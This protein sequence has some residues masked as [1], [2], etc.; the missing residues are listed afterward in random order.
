MKMFWSFYQNLSDIAHPFR[1]FSLAHLGY[2][3]ATCALVFWILKAYKKQDRAGK[4]RLENVVA[5]FLFVQE[6]FYYS[7]IAVNCQRNLFF[8]VLHLE[9]CTF[10]VFAGAST[11][12]HENQQVRF[13]A[14]LVG[15]LGAPIAIVYPATVTEIYPAFCY[16]IIG[17]YLS[18]G[19]LV[20]F[21][22]MMLSDEGL[23]TKKRLW[24][25]MAIL[26]C[27][28][29]LVYFFNLRFDTQ[30]M[31]VGNPPE[32]GIIRLVY[33]LTGPFFLPAA[34]VILSLY[35]WG[36]FLIVQKIQRGIY[37]KQGAK[38]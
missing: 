30:Y 8:E 9:L 10:C 18:H 32:I 27:M 24:N 11:V 29:T 12:F 3:A 35:Q 25:N 1:S 28:L 4:R 38:G 13:F 14:A 37:Q 7:W 31:F 5:V 19:A 34:V 2:V 33:D 21:A 36:L 6:I 22:L 26:A 20:L 23:L 17:F 15:L 16:R